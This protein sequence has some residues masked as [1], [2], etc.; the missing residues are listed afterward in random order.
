MLACYSTVQFCTSLRN[1]GHCC[2]AI[3]VVV[4]EVTLLNMSI[5]MGKLTCQNNR[6]IST[7]C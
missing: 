4:E 5:C 6:T 1:K 7:R 3:K 2:L